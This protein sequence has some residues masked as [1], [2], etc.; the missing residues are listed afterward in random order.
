MDSDQTKRLDKTLQTRADNEQF[1]GVVQLSQGNKIIFK[2]AVGYANRPWRVK[3]SVDTRF[4]I[5]SLTKLFTAVAILQLIDQRQLGFDTAVIPFLGISDTTI[6]H[7]VTV[8]HLLTHSSGIADDAEEEAGEDYADLWQNKPN[9]AVTEL[10]HFLPQFIHKTPNFPPGTAVRY[11]N[12]AYILLGLMLEKA[13]GS[14][15]RDYVRRHIFSAAGM[16]RTDFFHMADVHDE[17]A[18]SYTA[19]TTETGNRKWQRPI[20]MRPP[21]GSPDG[22]AYATAADMTAFMQALRDGRLLS[23]EMTQAIQSPQIAY[24]ERETY[25]TRYGYGPLFVFDKADHLSFYLGQGEDNGVSSKAV[26]YPDAGVTAV[27][28]ANQDYCTWPL[29]WQIQRLL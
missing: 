18:E 7:D 12:V 3:N 14:N 15:Y 22:G 19:V 20:Y 2:K 1:S 24:R 6:S 21:I 17:V 29:V 4:E 25:R 8:Y 27:L 23:A 28:L 10:A 5:A 16:R 11:N 13:T 9:Y 26:Y